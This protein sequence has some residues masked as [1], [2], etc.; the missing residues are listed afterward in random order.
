VTIVLVPESP[1]Y[2]IHRGRYTEAGKISETIALANEVT[3][4]FYFNEDDLID[5]NSQTN[6][7]AVRLTG[8]PVNQTLTD[9][10]IQTIRHQG[11]IYFDTFKVRD[12]SSKSDLE[13][14]T[15]RLRIEFSDAT[16]A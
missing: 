12:N 10:V 4:K 14:N 15:I 5:F 7:V 16:I 9:D 6:F 3:P 11:A 13:H 1:K 2:L 8:K